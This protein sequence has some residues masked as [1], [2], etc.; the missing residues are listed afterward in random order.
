ME[1]L[2]M[3]LLLRAYS[4][5]APAPAVAVDDDDEDMEAEEGGCHKATVSSPLPDTRVP[6]DR[7]VAHTNLEWPVSV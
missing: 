3:L 5:P 6:S 1:H 2:F 4:D 7:N